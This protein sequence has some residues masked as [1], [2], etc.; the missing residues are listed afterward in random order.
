MGNVAEKITLITDTREKLALD[1]SY[2]KSVES[3]VIKKLDATDYSILGYEHKWGCERKARGDLVNTLVGDH[4]RFKRE[5][6]RLK[7]YDEAYILVEGTHEELAKYCLHFGNGKA[8]NTIYGTLLKYEKHYPVTV[9]FCKDRRFMSDYIIRKA[10]E[11]LQKKGEQN[12]Q[13]KEKDNQD[14]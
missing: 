1:F 5:M 10:Q 2:S 13:P 14:S 7:D 9:Q 3:V 12:D 6:E 4:D 11:Y 8:L